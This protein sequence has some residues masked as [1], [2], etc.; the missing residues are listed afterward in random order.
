MGRTAGGRTLQ[1]EMITLAVIASIRHR[2]TPYD[3]LLMQGVFRNSARSQIQDQIEE[4]PDRWRQAPS[5]S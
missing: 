4:W 5:N 2:H 3:T 1:N